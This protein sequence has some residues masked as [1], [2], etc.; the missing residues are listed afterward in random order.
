[1]G[2]FGWPSGRKGHPNEGVALLEQAVER[3]PWNSA[4]REDLVKALEI[5]GNAEQAQA[6]RQRRW[7]ERKR[8]GDAVAEASEA[9]DFDALTTSAME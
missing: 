2:E 9:D 3:C 1:M 7:P 5:V 8:Q 6:V 4:W